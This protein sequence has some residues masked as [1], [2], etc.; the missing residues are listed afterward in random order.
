MK[1][2]AA[3][4]ALAFGV[5]MT[6]SAYALDKAADAPGASNKAE[7]SKECSAEADK[8]K[9]HGKPRKEFREKCKHEKADAMAPK[10]P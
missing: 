4:A 6:G 1:L 5:A 7:V 2:T 10:K 9:L 8:Q 3:L